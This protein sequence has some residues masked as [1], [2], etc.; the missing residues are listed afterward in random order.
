M[1]LQQFHTFYT[2]HLKIRFNINTTGER[3]SLQEAQPVCEN[4]SLG[5]IEAVKLTL[6]IYFF[7]M[8]IISFL[9]VLCCATCLFLQGPFCHGALKLYF[10][11]NMFSLNISSNYNISKS[12]FIKLLRAVGAHYLCTLLVSNMSPFFRLNDNQLGVFS[13]RGYLPLFDLKNTSS[14]FPLTN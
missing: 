8:F 10:L 4:S 12:I 6:S 1:I 14:Y 13:F 2:Q 9:R 11:C 5:F 7:K 3:E